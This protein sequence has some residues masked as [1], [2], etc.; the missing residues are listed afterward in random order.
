MSTKKDKGAQ[1]EQPWRTREKVVYRILQ[2]H[3]CCNAL[4]GTKSTPK[5]SCNAY[6]EFLCVDLI[7]MEKSVMYDCLHLRNVLLLL[8]VLDNTTWHDGRHQTRVIFGRRNNLQGSSF[9]DSQ[10]LNYWKRQ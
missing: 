3:G 5:L 10:L 8:N 7:D 6:S 2:K 4:D 1:L 9:A